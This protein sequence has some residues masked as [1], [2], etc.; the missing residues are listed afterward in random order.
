[1]T[2][3][4]ASSRRQEFWWLQLAVHADHHTEEHGGAE[5][6][7]AD[8]DGGHLGVGGLEADVVLLGVEVLH[9]RLVADEGD[10]DVAALGGDLL[11]DEDV[12]AAEDAGL[13]HRVAV[14]AQAEDVAAAA[15]HAALD[16]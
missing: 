16:A 6:A 3:S 8:E 9:R 10:H 12:V 2:C 14:D 5:V 15:D 4:N 11:A 13:D 1:S 7:G